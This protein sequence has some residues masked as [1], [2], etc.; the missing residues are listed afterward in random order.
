MVAM[1]Q[2]HVR[3]EMLP[4]MMLGGKGKAFAD[5]TRFNL[6]KKFGSTFTSQNVKLFDAQLC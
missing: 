1:F 2:W 4:R 5:C 3:K 6:G